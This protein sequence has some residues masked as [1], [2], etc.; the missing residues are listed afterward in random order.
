MRVMCIRAKKRAK[1]LQIFHMCKYFGK[2]NVIFRDFSRFCAINLAKPCLY[3]V[4]KFYWTKGRANPKLHVAKIFAHRLNNAN[5]NFG[6][7]LARP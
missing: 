3:G 5:V 7:F 2:K 1:L 4:V 6:G